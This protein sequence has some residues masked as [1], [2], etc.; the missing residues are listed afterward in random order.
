M[1]FK[2]VTYAAAAVIISAAPVLADSGVPS[3]YFAGGGCFNFVLGGVQFT[4][5]NAGLG[6]TNDPRGGQATIDQWNNLIMLVPKGKVTLERLGA[7]DVQV[8]PVG[9]FDYKGVSS[10]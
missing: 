6:G 5:P 4:K 9:G 1:T 7:V 8:C 2:T 3:S 10:P